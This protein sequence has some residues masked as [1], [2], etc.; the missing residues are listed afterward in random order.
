MRITVCRSVIKKFI[1]YTSFISYFY[2][3]KRKIKRLRK[4]ALKIP[5]TFIIN[6]ETTFLR[7]NAYLMS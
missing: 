1:Y 2:Y 3:F 5:D 6:N 4:T 7:V